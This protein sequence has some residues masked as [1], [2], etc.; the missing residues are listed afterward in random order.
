MIQAAGPS[1]SVIRVRNLQTSLVVGRDAWGR[2]GKAQPVLL[3]AS[4]SLREPFESA[5]NEDAVTEST[6]HYG[7]L[8]KAI[9][10]GCQEFSDAHTVE[11]KTLIALAFEIVSRLTQE[12]FDPDSGADWRENPTPPI[13]PGSIMN[14]LEINIMLPKASLLGGGISF[15][16]SLMFGSSQKE[17]ILEACVLTLH[18]LK[19]PTL[20][21]VNP[22]ERLARQLVV[23]TVNVDGIYH[24]SATD[25]YNEIEEIVVKV[26][27]PQ[28]VLPK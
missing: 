16:N 20:I 1:H 9:L 23:A 14:L 19:V 4:V 27:Q 5:S 2:R 7:S 17:P 22:N 11:H 21:G 10:Q 12:C 8:S 28:K 13:L 3:S 6:V 18:D 24:W 25:S 15:T 26:S